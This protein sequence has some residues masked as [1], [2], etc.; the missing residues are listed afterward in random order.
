MRFENVRCRKVKLKDA[1]VIDKRAILPNYIG[2][3]DIL[4]GLE[5]IEK[6]TGV[7]NTKKNAG[8]CDIRSNKFIFT[9]EHILYGKLRPNLNKVALPD[10]DGICSTDIYPILN[11]KDKAIKGYIYHLLHGQT[12]VK[13]ASSS[14]NGANLPRVNEK[15]ILDFEIPLPPL[16]IQMQITKTLD[17][18]A[19][20]L[21]MR[22]Q[23]LAELDIL[24]KSTFY[25]MFG[26]NEQNA[27][28][29]DIVSFSSVI[30]EFRYG[31]SIKSSYQQNGYPILRIP[32][33]IGGS[34][35]LDDLQRNDTPET[36]YQRLKLIENDLLFVR[37][38][39]NPDNTGR[40][41][42]VRKHHEGF[43][44]ASYLI[45]ARIDAKKANLNIIYLSEL[46]KTAA[47]RKQMKD[48]SKTSA[49]QY[50]IN[51]EGLGSLKI[52]LPPL[53]LQNQFANIVTKIE[54][55]KALVKK[56]ID[57]TQHLFDSLMS[58][59]FE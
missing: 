34:I 53:P 52:F 50:N 29:W 7:I 47:L 37:T 24:I 59:Y 49:G 3:E 57:E 17:I 5:D 39:G 12:F 43:V 4:I 28:G 22:K 23:Q 41:A 20:L 6:E 44:Y 45:R 14:T 36:E 27:K 33:I 9:S 25:D 16:E 46:L 2:N 31:T 42:L 26:D 40:S 35:N 30:T 8:E 51:I 32:N 10:F 13:Y 48:N 19:E 56:A 54:E 11:K 18:T 55:Q 15:I 21:A 58:E 38:N 1:I